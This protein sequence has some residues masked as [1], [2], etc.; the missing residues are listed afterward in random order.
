M[1]PPTDPEG[2]SGGQHLAST[3]GTFRQESTAEGRSDGNAYAETTKVRRCRAFG[4]WA[5]RVS[6]LRPLACEARSGARGASARAGSIVLI[7]SGFPLQVGSEALAK[8]REIRRRS[9]TGAQSKTVVWLPCP[10][11]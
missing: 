2:T 11:R 6:N 9:G 5:R 1:T 4:G 8:L 7:C 3:I 10:L